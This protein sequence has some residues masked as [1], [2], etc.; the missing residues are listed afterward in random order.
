MG[1]Q[2]SGKLIV[3]IVIFLIT[4]LAAH[5][6]PRQVK[7]LGQVPLNDYLKN[8]NGYQVNGSVAL[9]PEIFKFL[10][11]DDY[12]FTSYRNNVGKIELYVGYYYSAN[13]IS[14]AHSPLAC[15]PGQGWKIT[16]PIIRSLF[17]D[18]G[19]E[20]HYAELIASQEGRKELVFYW[21]QAHH[22]TTP[23]I[24]LNKINT[25]Y[26]KIM[27]DQE[28]HAFV[29]VSVSFADTTEEK[30]RV[31]GIEFIKAFYPV[32]SEFN[33]KNGLSTSL[34]LSEARSLRKNFGVAAIGLA[35][36]TAATPHSIRL[37]N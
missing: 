7:R 37:L 19:R 3:L 4:C 10:D 16:Q 22:A 17:I 11:L 8:I 5:F 29:R 35:A 36:E 14:A 2:K 25:L 34:K 18:D 24:F 1:N 26:N 20:V 33:D 30:A 32:F 28:D 6:S 27:N 31:Q 15:F 23:H 12:T 9:E 21:Y 13:K